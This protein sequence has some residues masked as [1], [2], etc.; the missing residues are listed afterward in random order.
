VPIVGLTVG[1]ETADG[2]SE[3]FL[4]ATA[5]GLQGYRP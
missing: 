3:A 5:T 1:S 2:G 4:E